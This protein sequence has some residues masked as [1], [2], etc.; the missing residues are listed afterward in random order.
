M[1]R[2]KTPEAVQAA[3]AR[4]AAKLFNQL[5]DFALDYEGMDATEV[6]AAMQLLDRLMPDLKAVDY[7]SPQAPVSYAPPDLVTV[8]QCGWA[9]LHRKAH[10]RSEPDA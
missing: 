10:P 9:A 5:A 8:D 1:P 2:K 7:E 3:D 6:R 4:K